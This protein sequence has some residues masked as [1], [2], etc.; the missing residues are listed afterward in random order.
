MGEEQCVSC[1]MVPAM[2]GVPCVRTV[3][4]KTTD[5]ASDGYM[6]GSL[7]LL[8]QMKGVVIIVSSR[9]GTA[10]TRIISR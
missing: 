5:A 6:L 3:Y 7:L 2:I 4:K 9:F 8:L 1:L 10:T